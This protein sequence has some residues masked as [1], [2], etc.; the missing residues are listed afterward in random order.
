MYIKFWQVWCFEFDQC[1]L[2]FNHLKSSDIAVLYTKVIPL[3]I[4]LGHW[5]GT[6]LH[7]SCCALHTVLKDTS[8][9]PRAM[10]SMGRFLLQTD[11]SQKTSFWLYHFIAGLHREI[12]S[13]FLRKNPILRVLPLWLTCLPKAYLKKH[14]Y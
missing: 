11:F 4:Y 12:I 6:G 5:H 14:F 9:H 1:N 7:R 13:Y 8:A 10:F 2:L 3:L